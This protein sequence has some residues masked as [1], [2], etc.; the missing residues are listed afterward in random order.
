MS[1]LMDP[2]TLC[3]ELGFALSGLMPFARA[4]A[5]GQADAVDALAFGRHVLEVAKSVDGLPW[6]G[7]L[8]ASSRHLTREELDALAEGV[9]P[10]PF[11]LS[12]SA[13][14]AWL[15]RVDRSGAEHALGAGL[16]RLHD[17]CVMRGFAYVR[18]DEDVPLLRD[19]PSEWA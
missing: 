17:Y 19:L 18:I 3:R 15:L 1:A 2:K 9:P 16:R 7:V 5:Q 13:E 12:M 10:Q 8:E 11:V 4:G 14:H 6:Q